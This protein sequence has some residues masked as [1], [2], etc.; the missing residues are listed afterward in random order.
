MLRYGELLYD[1][2]VRYVPALEKS[3]KV[4]TGGKILWRQFVHERKLDV[5]HRQISVSLINIDPDG[6]INTM[7]LPRCAIGQGL[8][9]IHGPGWMADGQS[10]AARSRWE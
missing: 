5:A 9:G 10:L 2:S 1:E 7:K 6:V 3:F 8:R 4:T